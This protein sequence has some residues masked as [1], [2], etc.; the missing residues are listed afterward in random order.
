MC[1]A[2]LFPLGNVS[3]KNPCADYVF[4]PRA[5]AMQRG[6]K[7]LDDLHGLRIG[8]ADPDDLSIRPSRGRSGNAD[9]VANPHGARI[10]HNRLPRRSCCKVLAWHFGPLRRAGKR[11]AAAPHA[12]LKGSMAQAGHARAGCRKTN[13]F[14]ATTFWKPWD[15]SR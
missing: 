10:P 9:V 2:D 3:H 4:Q 12:K 5:G 14:A 13:L 7:I 11:I 6:F 8:V 15:V 1:L